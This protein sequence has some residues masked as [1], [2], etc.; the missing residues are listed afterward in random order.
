MGGVTLVRRQG[1]L[2]GYAAVWEGRSRTV[3]S[4]DLP[5]QEKKRVVAEWLR[6]VKA[7]EKVPPPRS[8]A[9]KEL[10][11][12]VFKHGGS[13]PQADKFRVSVKGF[14]RKIF[15]DAESAIAYKNRCLRCQLEARRQAATVEV[16]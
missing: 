8:R 10:P 11:K 5:L 14:S 12:H 1:Q 9:G 13:G 3:I 15:E 4:P 16:D 6:A 2:V 7:G